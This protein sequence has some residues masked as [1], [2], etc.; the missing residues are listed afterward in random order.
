M[1]LETADTKT[2]LRLFIVCGLA[3]LMTYLVALFV[4]LPSLRMSYLVFM[5]FGPLFST[6]PSSP[7]GCS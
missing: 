4:P 5:A 3:T 1:S 7:C 6:R 2:Y